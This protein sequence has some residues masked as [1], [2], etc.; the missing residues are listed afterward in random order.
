MP[1]QNFIKDG[2]GEGKYARRLDTHQ[3][4]KRKIVLKPS[5]LT[6]PETDHDSSSSRFH[7]KERGNCGRSETGV[8]QQR[9]PGAAMNSHTER[10]HDDSHHKEEFVEESSLNAMVPSPAARGAN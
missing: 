3:L 6:D 5:W 8:L 7:L 4:S 1:R 10:E 2:F 9:D